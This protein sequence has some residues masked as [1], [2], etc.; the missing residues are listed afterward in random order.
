MQIRQPL[1]ANV[2]TWALKG[3]KGRDFRGFYVISQRTIWVVL[4]SLWLFKVAKLARWRSLSQGSDCV[5]FFFLTV[6]PAIA[7]ISEG[8]REIVPNNDVL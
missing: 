6:T 7:S 3:E 2:V 8:L 5:L 1:Q 4:S